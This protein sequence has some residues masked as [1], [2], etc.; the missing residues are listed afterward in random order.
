MNK[1]RFLYLVGVSLLAG[2]YFFPVWRISL[3]VPQYPKEISIHIGISGIKNGT[4]KAM[5]IMNV[6]NHNIGMKEIDPS[7]IPE[8]IYFPWILGILVA[9]GVLSTFPEKIIYRLMFLVLTLTLLSLA[10]YDFYLW[11]YRYGHDLD[12]DAPIKIE[13]GSFQPPL[14]GKKN[15][16]NFIVE[17]FPMSGALF[18]VASGVILIWAL[19]REKYRL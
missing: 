3:S 1:N 19:I 15:M 17:S 13:G 7:A 9:L 10:L 5:E 6:L 12:E 18:P 16:A 4:K 2:L 8:L 14:I 11:E